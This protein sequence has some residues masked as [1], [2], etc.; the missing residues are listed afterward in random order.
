MD[1]LHGNFWQLL[2]QHHRLQRSRKGAAASNPHLAVPFAAATFS[3]CC[4]TQLTAAALTAA[5]TGCPRAAAYLTDSVVDGPVRSRVL[6]SQ[7]RKRLG[8]P[9]T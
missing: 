3:G 6:V 2:L 8:T 5:L 4:A 9:F 1:K 7:Q